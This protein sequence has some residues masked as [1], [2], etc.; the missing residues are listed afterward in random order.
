MRI[1]GVGIAAAVLVLATGCLREGHPVPAAAPGTTTT[2]AAATTTPGGPDQRL[3]TGKLAE[4]LRMAE[5]LVLP[6]EI[7]PAY[8]RHGSSDV[9]TSARLVISTGQNNAAQDAADRNGLLAGFVSQRSTGGADRDWLTHGIMRFP[10][11]AA[12]EK[13]AD[14]LQTAALTTGGLFDTERRKPAAL[15]GVPGARYSTLESRGH[16]DGMALVPYR[17]YV[18]LTRVT[19]ATGDIAATVGRAVERQRPLLDAFVPTPRDALP[20]LAYDPG[21]LMDLSVGENAS[22]RGVYGPHGALLFAEDQAAAVARYPEL[23]VDALANKGTT[24][25]RTRDEAAAG[26]LAPL[27][28]DAVRAAWEKDPAAAPA[29]VPG[30]RCLGSGTGSTNAWVCWVPVGRYVGEAWGRTETEAHA[31][32]RE[33]RAVL[34]AAK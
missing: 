21:R 3:R 8:R 20:D 28:A 25:Y 9:L 30:A 6:T 7:D 13:A 14:D 22:G 5:V 24:V 31:T 32:L 23:G 29:D 19:T 4:G 18:V 12:A 33:Q 27:L 10:D 2:T 34:A 16:T 17:D 26:Q 1:L 15:P 11:A